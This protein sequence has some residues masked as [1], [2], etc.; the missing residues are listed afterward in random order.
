MSYAG[1]TGNVSMLDYLLKR[2]I[3]IRFDTLKSAV[4]YGHLN[5]LEHI[6][7]N[8]ITVGCGFTSTEPQDSETLLKIAAQFGYINI[9]EYIINEQMLYGYN[10]SFTIPFPYANIVQTAATYGHLDIINKYIGRISDGRMME[11]YLYTIQH[12]RYD[13][14]EIFFKHGKFENI[15]WM[16]IFSTYNVKFI[17]YYLKYVHDTTNLFHIAI[18]SGSAMSVRFLFYQTNHAFS[19]KKKSSTITKDL[20]QHRRCTTELIHFCVSQGVQI[21]RNNVYDAVSFHNIGMIRYFVEQGNLITFNMIKD[22]SDQNYALFIHKRFKQYF[23][24]K[25]IRSKVTS[26]NQKFKCFEDELES[27]HDLM[28]D[29]YYLIYSN[30]SGYDGCTCYDCLENLDEEVRLQII[31]DEEYLINEMTRMRPNMCSCEY[32][33]R[34]F[35]NIRNYSKKSKKLLRKTRHSNTNLNRQNKHNRKHRNTKSKQ[36][37]KHQKKCG[38]Q[39]NMFKKDR[40]NHQ[41]MLQIFFN[42]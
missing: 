14:I 13:A 4:M 1:Q 8:N 38:Q 26:Y 7:E 32:V 18:K 6:N 2:G 37:K 36:E 23:S 31:M 27:S 3:P 15:P 28:N 21:T 41:R 35:A 9:I 42:V 16:N 22:I 24:T 12:N 29:K 30:G 25:H 34:H 11:L 19:F 20:V 40:K 5:I 39:K 10:Y 17:N 33:F